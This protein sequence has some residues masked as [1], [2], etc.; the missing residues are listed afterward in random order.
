MAL[1]RHAATVPAWIE[2]Q[3]LSSDRTTGLDLAAGA[4]KGIDRVPRGRTYC[5]RFYEVTVRSCR[6]VSMFP[7][8][9]LRT[10]LLGFGHSQWPAETSGL[11]SSPAVKR[12]PRTPRLHGTTSVSSGLEAG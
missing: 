6:G 11:S 12:V 7:G 9:G 2:Q 3:I 8:S 10:I 1:D 4:G 5:R